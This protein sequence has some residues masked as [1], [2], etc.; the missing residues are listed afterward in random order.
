MIVRVGNLLKQRLNTE[1]KDLTL[2]REEIHKEEQTYPEEMRMISYEQ[3]YEKLT[4]RKP[5]S[6][7]V[8]LEKV[9]A[10]M[11]QKTEKYWN[12]VDSE[13]RQQLNKENTQVRSIEYI[14]SLKGEKKVVVVDGHLVVATPLSKQAK[15]T[16]FKFNVEDRDISVMIQAVRAYTP[17]QQPFNVEKIEKFHKQQVHGIVGVVAD[18]ET[19]ST[20]KQQYSAKVEMVKSQEQ[21]SMNS[22]PQRLWYVRQCL[23]DIKEQ[24]K[25][26]SSA[27]TIANYEMSALN[28]IKFELEL[29]EQKH[30]TLKNAT[31]KIREYLKVALYRNLRHEYP[32]QADQKK[33]QG[34]IIYS[35]KPHGMLNLTIITPDN[36][37]LHFERLYAPRSLRP[38][39][40]W[41]IK[42]TIKAALRQD[43]PEPECIYN[44]DYLRTFDNVTISL[45]AMKKNQKYVVARDNDEEPRFVIVAEPKEKLTVVEILLRN[46]TLIKLVPSINENTYKVHMNSS[47]VEVSPIKAVVRQYGRQQRNI[48]TVHVEKHNEGRPTLVIKVRD[49]RLRIVYDGENLMVQIAKRMAKGQLTGLCGDMNNQH[50]EELTGPRGC[51][52]DLEEDFIRAFSLTSEKKIEG[53]WEC[54]E[55]IHPRDASQHQIEEHRQKEQK[56]Q[57]FH[58]QRMQHQQQEPKDRSITYGQGMTLVTSMKEVQGKI[59]F[60]LEHITKC[61]HGYRQSEEESIMVPFACLEKQDPRAIQI[62]RQIQSDMPVLTG[63]LGQNHRRS[64]VQIQ[65]QQAKVCKQE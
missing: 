5:E 43:R 3:E 50:L 29:P 31:H 47:E 27:C 49:Q 21:L 11:T 33:I 38:N 46:S 28:H 6:K 15:L 59:C 17:T 45:E 64:V 61:A 51:N 34:E 20:G 60:S 40:K 4:N 1:Q 19:R 14:V 8:H 63:A 41:S 32:V 35:E 13:L 9:L 58:Q 56:M 39:T 55:G 10:R 26:T 18:I 53:K 24:K 65:V 62:Q 7:K 44:G 42:Q 22:I 12:Q 23:D 37:K 16:E 52:F 48:L 54:P 30:E 36:E 2:S 25:E 57:Q